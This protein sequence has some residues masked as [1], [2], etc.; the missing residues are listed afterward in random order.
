MPRPAQGASARITLLGE[1]GTLPRGRRG[2]VEDFDKHLDSARLWWGL[3][4]VV[5]EAII[6]GQATGE[7]F[8]RVAR[9]TRSLRISAG[10]SPSKAQVNAAITKIAIR[11]AATPEFSPRI[12]EKERPRVL[13]RVRQTLVFTALGAV[14]LVA[15][16]VA[17]DAINIIEL[18]RPI[19][20]ML[21][22][23]GID[24]PDD[25]TR[26]DESFEGAY[27]PIEGDS[28]AVL[29]PAFASTEESSEATRFGSERLT[30]QGG[31]KDGAK[32]KNDPA[33]A[34]EPPEEP[35]ADIDEQAPKNQGDDG[36]SRQPT[37]RPEPTPRPQPTPR[38]EPTPSQQT[39]PGREPT[40]RPEQT[41][42]PEQ[43]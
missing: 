4:D 13:R 38:P 8:R 31:E 26:T 12:P 16:L 35:P 29:T 15:L 43:P 34:A 32:D 23:F 36:R 25:Q 17:G 21:D 1:L 33:T 6:E 18:P 7:P 30:S 19:R 24:P 20:V 41:E 14:A 42:R 28:G 39:A 10:P 5:L 9:Y 37:A 11:L 2:Q 40:P 27:P 3:D 22:R